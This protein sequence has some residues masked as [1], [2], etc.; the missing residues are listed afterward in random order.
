MSDAAEIFEIAPEPDPSL[1]RARASNTPLHEQ[2]RPN[3]WEEVVG[4]DKALARIETI[5]RRGLSG[6]AYWI[7]GQSGTGKTTI[8]R[9]IAR[10]I[11]DD[12]FIEEI[13]A[14]ELTATRLG[15]FLD[16]L[17]TCSWGK[18]GRVLIVNESHGLRA[19][20]IRRLL[21]AIESLPSHAAMIFTT[22]N[23]AQQDIFADQLDANPLLSRC[24]LLQLS[25]RDLAQT[26]ADRAQAIAEREGLD[27]KD[28]KAFY[29][30]AQACRN[31]LRA[32]LQA[33]ESGEMLAE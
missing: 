7:T 11:A 31:N 29:K 33:I 18:G 8:A 32:M 16:A 19:D 30:L 17:A 24:T 5:R 3:T 22:T 10:E 4:Q 21:V 9:L 2:Y 12:L 6:R 23:E 28:N 26:F 1:A 27:G 14:G 13:D 20:T 25:R 15:D